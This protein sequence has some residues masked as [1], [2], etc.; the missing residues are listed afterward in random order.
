MKAAWGRRANWCRNGWQKCWR[1]FRKFRVV[2][3]VEWE[4]EGLAYL[5]P[6]NGEKA[7][8]FVNGLKKTDGTAD[9]G[10]RIAIHNR[11]ASQVHAALAQGKGNAQCRCILHQFSESGQTLRLVRGVAG[12]ALG[13]A[14][15]GHGFRPEGCRGGTGGGCTC[16]YRG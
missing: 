13:A 16:G 7:I 15:Q 5:P 8:A 9:D 3:A 12:C 2:R 11:E 1:E 6:S 10:C 4:R 14:Q